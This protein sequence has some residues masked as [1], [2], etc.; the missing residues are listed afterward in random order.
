MLPGLRQ[1]R[2]GCLQSRQVSGGP[3]GRVRAP[4]RAPVA[5]RRFPAEHSCFDFDARM[6]DGT[7]LL[8]QVCA[9]LSP[10]SGGIVP[11]GELTSEPGPRG[12]NLLGSPESQR[13]WRFEYSSIARCE[14]A[15]M[16]LPA[17]PF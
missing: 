12:G 9:E 15:T 4:G 10:I 14:R 16:K 17:T 2:P 6:Q 7:V 1:L 13:R 3:R 5:A 8:V 11:M